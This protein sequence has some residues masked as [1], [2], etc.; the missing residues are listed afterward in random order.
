MADPDTTL[1]EMRNV[2]P[3]GFRLM[4]EYINAGE[5]PDPLDDRSNKL[6]RKTAEAFKHAGLVGLLGRAITP[7]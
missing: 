6:L 3:T 1:G 4:Y 5:L 7:P 2:T